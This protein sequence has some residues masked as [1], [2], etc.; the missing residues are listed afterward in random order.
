MTVGKNDF[1]WKYRV[2][3]SFCKVTENFVLG[4][5]IIFKLHV[6]LMQLQI[7]LILPYSNA[8]SISRITLSLEKISAILI[9]QLISHETV[10]P[11]FHYSF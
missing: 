3:C 1:R 10:F 5:K 9:L 7:L 6:L 2:I 11:L 4:L 8:F